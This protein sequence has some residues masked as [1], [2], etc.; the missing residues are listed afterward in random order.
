[1]DGIFKIF[2]VCCNIFFQLFLYLIILICSSG[3]MQIREDL[4]CRYT[5]TMR[6]STRAFAWHHPC[7]HSLPCSCAT[8]CSFSIKNEF[9]ASQTFARVV[10]SNTDRFVSFPQSL[11]LKS[12][13]RTRP[14]LCSHF[15]VS[16]LIRWLSRAE[17][18]CPNRIHIQP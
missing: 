9:V 8:T 14:L 15:E 5:V 16:C 6:P 11:L 1:M 3:G 2:Y 4:E 12:T 17:Q 18:G 10:V 13:R 7:S